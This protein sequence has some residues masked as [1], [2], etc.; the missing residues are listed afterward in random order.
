[1]PDPGR[2]HGDPASRLGPHESKEANVRWPAP[3]LTAMALV[4]GC[5]GPR[6]QAVHK[7]S[8]ALALGVAFD[9]T[10]PGRHRRLSAWRSIASGSG[11]APISVI[12]DSVVPAACSGRVLAH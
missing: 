2:T 6:G 12:H 10:Q 5:A 7:A 11:S 8:P 3:V 1:M 9:P 4:G